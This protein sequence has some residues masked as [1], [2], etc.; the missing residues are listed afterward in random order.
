[1]G[2]IDKGS[3]R[4]LLQ[5]SQFCLH[6]FL[7]SSL[8]LQGFVKEQDRRLINEGSGNGNSLSLPAG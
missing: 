3:P 2:N 8:E 7:A 5:M 1:M 4:L 6:M